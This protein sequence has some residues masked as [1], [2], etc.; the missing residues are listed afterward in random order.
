VRLSDRNRL[1]GGDEAGRVYFLGLASEDLGYSLWRSDGT[2]AGTVR[3]TPDGIEVCGGDLAAAGGKVYLALGDQAHGCEIWSSDGTAAGTVLVKDLQPGF[4]GS[5]PEGLTAFHGRIYFKLRGFSGAKLWRTDGT[6]AGTVA[7]TDSHLDPEFNAYGALL[8][9]GDRLYFLA[10]QG[11]SDTDLWS[12]DGTGAGTNPA[13]SLTFPEGA[14][15][16]PTL[17]AAGNRLLISGR[18]GSGSPLILLASDG[19]TAGTKR[20]AEAELSS[21]PKLAAFGGRF[22]FQ[23][24]QFTSPD[25]L[26]VS[27]GSPAGTHPLHAAD[28]SVITNAGPFAPLGGKLVFLANGISGA[29][30]RGLWQ[31]DGTQAGTRKIP[32]VKPTGRFDEDQLAG[33]AARLFFAAYDPGSGTELW[34]LIP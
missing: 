12:S 16:E 6:A 28:G 26:W 14:I 13:V 27:D 9:L 10:N 8:P 20:L 2:E 1:L 29:P 18:L 24:G 15:G 17:A 34:S 5:D 32:G 22:Y 11:E 4:S 7:V 21:P 3:L 31:T 25:Q 19:T 30:E 23:A 33:S